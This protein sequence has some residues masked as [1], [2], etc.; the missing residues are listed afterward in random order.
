MN[1]DFINA[2]EKN[3]Q[4]YGREVPEWRFAKGEGKEQITEDDI[5]KIS[6]NLSLIM[7]FVSDVKT[8]LAY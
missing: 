6:T 2:L 5:K 3:C 1:H 7:S 8:D 4:F